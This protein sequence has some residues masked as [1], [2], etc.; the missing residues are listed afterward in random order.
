[1]T[2]AERATLIAILGR[3]G[4][5]H[6][7]E[8]DA[9]ALAATRM[10]ARLGVGWGDVISGGADVAIRPPYSGPLYAAM[11]AAAQEAMR[12]AMQQRAAES[13]QQQ[14]AQQAANAQY[15]SYTAQM[16]VNAV[17]EELRRRRGEPKATAT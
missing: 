2:N 1:M 11:Q 17:I 8:R 9:A 14:A 5:E 6:T 15:Q 7:G 16:D 12:A 10:L 13:H 4:S 3:L